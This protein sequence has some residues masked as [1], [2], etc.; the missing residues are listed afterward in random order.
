MLKALLTAGFCF[1]FTVSLFPITGISFREFTLGQTKAEVKKSILGKYQKV[2][3]AS[4]GD[5][6]IETGEMS[7]ARLYFDH[8]DRLYLIQVE[9]KWGE[10]AKV[11]E[12]LIGKYGQPN[13][14][15]G[16][17]FNRSTGAFLMARWSVD[18]R[19]K[20]SAWE[21]EDCRTSKVNPCIIYVEY[22][23]SS[24]RE[25]KIRFEQKRKEEVKKKKEGETYD[26]L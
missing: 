2:N 20:I 18:K 13:D 16:E 15:S 1:I 5:M 8:Q 23:D 14:Y 26:G 21:T 3:Y 11:K 10:I 22:L 17:E 24:L 4:N 9:I 6:T 12:R 19:Y 7:T 25:G